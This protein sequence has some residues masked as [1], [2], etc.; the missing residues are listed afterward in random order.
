MPWYKFTSDYGRSHICRY[1]FYDHKL[2]KNTLREELE[3]TFR[4]QHVYEGKAVIV[5]RLPAE[6]KD[7]D[8]RRLLW[9]LRETIKTLKSRHRVIVKMEF[10]QTLLDKVS[11][12]ENRR[13]DI[14]TEK[15][16]REWKRMIEKATP[17]AGW[18]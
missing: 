4:E 1:R 15:Y 9:N 11:E 10:P 7:L 13:I 18:K 2:D 8:V 16:G 6:E 14:R 3:D 12:R 5:K 17:P